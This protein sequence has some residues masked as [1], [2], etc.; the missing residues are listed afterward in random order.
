MLPASAPASCVAASLERPIFGV[1]RTGVPKGVPWL[2]VLALL[3]LFLFTSEG[4]L[5]AA[6]A[7]ATSLPLPLLPPLLKRT[8][9]ST[10]NCTVGTVAVAETEYALTGT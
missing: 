7:A 9:S 5:L 1:P 6:A 8:A 3:P 4:Q 10:P 2:G